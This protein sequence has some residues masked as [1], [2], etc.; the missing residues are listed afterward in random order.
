MPALALATSIRKTAS[1]GVP[2]FDNLVEL[3]VEMVIVFEARP[4]T[5]DLRVIEEDKNRADSMRPNSSI[6]FAVP[7]RS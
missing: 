1:I 4:H 7:S 3:E 6:S 5:G 2:L